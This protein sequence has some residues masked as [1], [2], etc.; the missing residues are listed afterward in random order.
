MDPELEQKQER[1]E[2]ESYLEFILKFYRL[3]FSFTMPMMDYRSFKSNVFKPVVAI[4]LDFPV[5]HDSQRVIMGTLML[6]RVQFM[7]NPI[8]STY[9]GFIVSLNNSYIVKD[10][11]H[12]TLL[13]CST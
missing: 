12:T 2:D 11:A 1:K 4:I 5:F 6:C 10:N 3:F 13:S 7:T 8:P 9:T